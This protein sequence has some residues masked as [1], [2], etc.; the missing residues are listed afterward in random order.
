MKIFCK[1]KSVQIPYKFTWLKSCGVFLYH[2]FASVTLSDKNLALF[3]LYKYFPIKEILIMS[4]GWLKLRV[5]VRKMV[6]STY[7]YFIR[8]Q[9]LK[10][11]KIHHSY[12]SNDIKIVISCIFHPLSSIHAKHNT[13]QRFSCSTGF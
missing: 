8:Y 4:S 12:H 5:R 13:S 1:C 6:F 10:P 11:A 3:K 7:A 9:A 2:H